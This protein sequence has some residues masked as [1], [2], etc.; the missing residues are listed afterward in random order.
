MS[1]IAMVTALIIPRQIIQNPP[2]LPKC[3]Y[4]RKRA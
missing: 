3:N 2:E 4:R 1:V